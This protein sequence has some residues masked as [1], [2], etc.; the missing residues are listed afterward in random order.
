M[1]KLAATAVALAA[2]LFSGTAGAQSAKPTILLVHGAFADS[3]SWN[4]VI[5]ILQKDGYPVVATPNPLRSVSTDAAYVSS[6][7]SSIDGPV[8]L[9]GHSY[10]GQVISN[11]AVGHKNVKALVFVAAFAPEKG[12]TIL[13]LSGKFPGSTLGDALAAPVA[14]SDGGVDLYIAQDKFRAQFAQDVPT[15]LAATMAVGQRPIT[16][17]ALTEKSDEPAWK[18]L[19][20][21]FIYG[22]G[23]KNIPA[24][25]LAFVAERA[26]SKRTVVLAGASHALTVSQPEAVADLIKDAAK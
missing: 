8:V 3:S 18:N 14:L 1:T 26:G 11:A 20:S 10:G 16:E 15:E 13:E 19:P 25:G 21:F 12:E 7:V 23:D 5:N 9:V 2:A 17:A 4:G 24:K 6:V 22:D